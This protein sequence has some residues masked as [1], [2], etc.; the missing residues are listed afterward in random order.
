M[1]TGRSTIP[2]SYESRGI[3]PHQQINQICHR[4][5]DKHILSRVSTPGSPIVN[6]LS[7]GRSPVNPPPPP[8]QSKLDR[9]RAALEAGQFEQSIRLYLQAMDACEVLTD[10]DDINLWV[11]A[12]DATDIELLELLAKKRATQC[13]EVHPA[14][15]HE[16]TLTLLSELLRLRWKW[17]HPDPD[18]LAW[19]TGLYLARNDGH[20]AV[21]LVRDLAL[22]GNPRREPFRTCC[23]S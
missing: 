7:A 18:L 3:R 5:E 16:G 11:A 4:F 21:R 17:G 8:E 9:A 15:V 10:N 1:S 14:S 2:T 22:G 6:V 19:L 13:G 20:D 12:Q 23:Q